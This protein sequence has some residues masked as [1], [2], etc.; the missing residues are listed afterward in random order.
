R[1]LSYLLVDRATGVAAGA[2]SNLPV[3]AGVCVER[4]FACAV[5]VERQR[6][7]HAANRRGAERH[8]RT[9]VVV[10]V[11]AH[12]DNDNAGHRCGNRA[13]TL[14]LAGAVGWGG[15]RLVLSFELL[16]VKSELKTKNGVDYG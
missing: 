12:P 3:C 13:G 6:A 2:G 10:H 4:I 9:A 15:E 5:P 8:A 7:N 14:H 1:K 16:L 11:G